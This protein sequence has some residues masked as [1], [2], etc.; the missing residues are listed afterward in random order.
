M[1][2]G[3][4]VAF[5]DEQVAA[6]G[7]PTTD[8][9]AVQQDES[10][11]SI[12]VQAEDAPVITVE[13]H[14]EDAADPVGIESEPVEEPL[15]AAGTLETVDM[16]RLYNPNSGEHFYTGSWEE[17]R[18]SRRSR[19][20]I[21]GRGWVAPDFSRSPVFRLY[22]PNAGDHHYTLSAFERDELVDAGWN[23]EGIGWYSDD[24]QRIRRATSVQSQ[25]QDRLTQL[26]P[27]RRMK[28]R[29]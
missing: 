2:F 9:I 10:A 8:T 3:T 19:L 18:E 20:A 1:L 17:T 21:R 7:L 22:N 11:T 12:D 23:D 4:G 29:R 24:T 13:R 15:L 14:L 25:R 5:A 6:T 26:H 28:T 16:H 27:L